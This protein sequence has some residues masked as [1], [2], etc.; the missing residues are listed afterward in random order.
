M[1]ARFRLAHPQDRLVPFLSVPTVTRFS[2]P[3]AQRQGTRR[4]VTS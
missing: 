3:H 1:L 4:S 2:V